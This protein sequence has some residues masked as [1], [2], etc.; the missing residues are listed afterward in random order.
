MAET[1]NIHRLTRRTESF[2]WLDRYLER[3]KLEDWEQKCVRERHGN[4]L[5]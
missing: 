1:R 5:R 4:G 3:T 2:G